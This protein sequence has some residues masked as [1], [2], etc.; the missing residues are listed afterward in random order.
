MVYFKTRIQK[1]QLVMRHPVYIHFKT[2]ITK[3]FA[4][5]GCVV[6][7]VITHNKRSRGRTVLY[8]GQKSNYKPLYAGGRQYN[9][10]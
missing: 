7:Q 3:V 9:Y 4:A 2:L 1:T 8:L 10:E 5:F 6:C